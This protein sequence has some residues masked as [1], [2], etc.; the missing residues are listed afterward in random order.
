MKRIYHLAQ[1]RSHELG[2]VRVLPQL[3][4]AL[5]N[6]VWWIGDEAEETDARLLHIGFDARLVVGRD[7][8]L[9][10]EGHITPV[11]RLPEL[12]WKPLGE[13]FPLELPVSAMAGQV[14]AHVEVKLAA[15]EVPRQS[16]VLLTNFFL[17]K[18]Y[19]ETAPQIRLSR[20][21]FAASQ[22]GEVLVGG[23]ILPALPGTEYWAR[24]PLLLPAGFDLELPALESLLIKKLVPD[25]DALVLLHSNGSMETVPK[26]MCVPASRSGVRR[27]SE[28]G[29]WL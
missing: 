24:G 29:G 27:M 2:A 11:S 14:N 26:I 1:H 4:G 9:F 8:F 25:N 16:S 7:H 21:F 12:D 5:H 10:P 18:E 23:D 28:K 22:S 3:K 13:L 20:L 15:S 19:C 17:W 6:G